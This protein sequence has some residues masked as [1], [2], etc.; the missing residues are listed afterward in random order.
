[1]VCIFL[2]GVHVRVW[3]GSLCK[4]CMFVDGVCKLCECDESVQ[5]VGDISLC[6]LCVCYESVKGV[7]VCDMNL[8]KVYVC[9][10]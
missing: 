4:V 9:V 2:F 8:C 1:M 7:C 5:G 10:I 3:F 6:K